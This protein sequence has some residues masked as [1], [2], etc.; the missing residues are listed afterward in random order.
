MWISLILVFE[1]TIGI[2]VLNLRKQRKISQEELADMIDSNQVYISE[3]ERGMKLP[4]I[5]T[6]YNLAKAF[7]MTLAEFIAIIEKAIEESADWMFQ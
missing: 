5:K 7:G 1:K 2:I 6:L 3:I 4:S